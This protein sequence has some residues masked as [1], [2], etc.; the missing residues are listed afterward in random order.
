[1]G[2][3]FPKISPHISLLFLKT[4][5]FPKLTMAK[6]SWTVVEHF[7]QEFVGVG[8]RKKSQLGAITLIKFQSHIHTQPMRKVSRFFK[9]LANKTHS[10]QMK[11]NWSLEVLV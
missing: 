4:N 2:W 11:Q 10:C 7:R 3:K 8:S 9:L 5:L 1:M 6:L